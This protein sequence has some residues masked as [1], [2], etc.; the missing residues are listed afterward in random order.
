MSKIEK[1]TKTIIE[2][3]F[4]V[5]FNKMTDTEINDTVKASLS[6]ISSFLAEGRKLGY[7][8]TIRN[9]PDSIF[10]SINEEQSQMQKDFSRVRDYVENKINN[11]SN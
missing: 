8:E 9:N 5:D 11:K 2:D 1:I 7:I 10:P 6:I 4:I 3:F